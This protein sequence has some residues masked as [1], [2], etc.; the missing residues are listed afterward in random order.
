MNNSN[1]LSI[2]TH[3][4]PVHFLDRKLREFWY[5]L[6]ARNLL[7]L[8]LIA[9]ID[10]DDIPGFYALTKDQ[11]AQVE[12]SLVFVGRMSRMYHDSG[13]ELAWRKFTTNNKNIINR[14]CDV[15]LPKTFNEFS[16]QQVAHYIRSLELILRL[17][18]VYN[19]E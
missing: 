9:G 13:Y 3:A 5:S 6:N 15:E 19:G 14:I 1:V 4:Q 12:V 11:R 2:N 16:V 8:A 17:N 18:E 7:T 10:P